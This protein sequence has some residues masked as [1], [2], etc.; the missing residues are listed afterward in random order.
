MDGHQATSGSGSAGASTVTG[1]TSS[2]SVTSSSVVAISSDAG[3]LQVGFPVLFF[4]VCGIDVQRIGM[5]NCRGESVR[6]CGSLCFS[7]L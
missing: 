7:K 5:E 6:I 3:I 1:G 2:S 4:V